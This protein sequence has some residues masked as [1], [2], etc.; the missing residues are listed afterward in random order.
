MSRNYRWKSRC[1]AWL[2]RWRR[3]RSGRNRAWRTSKPRSGNMG[4]CILGRAEL[5]SQVA[6]LVEKPQRFV[7]ATNEIIS[8]CLVA[9]RPAIGEEL[10]HCGNWRLAWNSVS[11]AYLLQ[12]LVR[13]NPSFQEMPLKRGSGDKDICPKGTRGD[14]TYKLQSGWIR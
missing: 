10:R 8:R 2:S 14:P 5:K 13:R 6:D 3:R 4:V 7:L 1:K 11:R 12:R 9:V